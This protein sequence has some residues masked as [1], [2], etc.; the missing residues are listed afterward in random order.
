MLASSSR[1]HTVRVWDVASSKHRT[2][3]AAHTDRVLGVAYVNEG[4]SL[5]SG[6]SDGTIR[7]WD[8]STGRTTAKLTHQGLTSLATDSSGTVLATGSYDK[9][10]KIWDLPRPR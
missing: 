5:A 1:D 2:T 7:L 10:I 4:A 3:L 8:V 9:S 6:S